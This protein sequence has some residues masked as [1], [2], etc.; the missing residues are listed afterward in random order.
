MPEIVLCGHTGSKNRGCEALVR[1]TNLI[2]KQTGWEKVVTMT[3][4]NDYDRKLHLDQVAELVPYPKRTF[5]Q[6]AVSAA[7]R[8]LLH[9]VLLG[10]RGH[11]TPIFQRAAEQGV[12]LNIGGDTYCYGTPYMSYALNQL[13]E[14]NHVPTVFWGC[15][16]EA[17]CQTDPEMR[18]DLNRYSV[19]VARESM[20]FALL[21]Q[22]VEEKEKV[23]LACDP[24]FQLPVCEVP[25]PQAFQPNNTLGINL[26]PL[27]F[28]ECTDPTDKMYSNVRAL[29]DFVLRTTDMTICLIPHVYSSADRSGDL[30][31]LD[32]VKSFYADNPRVLLEDRELSCTELKYIISQ[33]RFFVG[34]R[35]HATIAAYSTGVPAIALSYSIKSR[36]I[37]KDLFGCEEGYAIPWQ[38]LQQEEL[39][40]EA[41]QNRLQQQEKSLRELYAQKLPGY[42]QS[43]LHATEQMMRRLTT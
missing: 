4:D 43:I 16:V 20:T 22:C 14:K 12:L 8:R 28:A 10:N 17:R 36:G 15:S 29:I 32:I 26:S 18:R 2:L 19:I 21:Q 41:F 27:V 40:R 33:C 25:L 1:S 13:A 37:A 11:F 24:A 5:M 38:D 31:V 23:L 6:K 42:K 35:T 30:Q 34:A 9:N 3:Y 7:A 39:L